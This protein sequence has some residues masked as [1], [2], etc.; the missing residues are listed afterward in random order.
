ML[1]VEELERN[2]QESNPWT[3]GPLAIGMHQMLWSGSQWEIILALEVQKFNAY[4]GYTQWVNLLSTTGCDPKE[5]M[6]HFVRDL[7]KFD[8]LNLEKAWDT[9]REWSTPKGAGVSALER[10]VGDP[11]VV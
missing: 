3:I 11:L 9:L 2:L 4:G 8:P 7:H 5:A 10:L 1:T 6:K